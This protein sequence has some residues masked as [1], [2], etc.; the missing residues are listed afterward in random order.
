M[1]ERMTMQRVWKIHDPRHMNI[2]GEIHTVMY[3]EKKIKSLL[4][5]QRLVLFR[6]EFF[7]PCSLFFTD[8]AEVHF[9]QMHVVGP[10][11]GL[12]QRTQYFWPSETLLEAE[13]SSVWG[14]AAGALAQQWERWRS[15]EIREYSH[16]FST[17]WK[18][19]KIRDCCSACPQVTQEYPAFRTSFLG[20]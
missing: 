18:K 2:E 10:E 9:P 15:L 4:Y 16:S 19:Q 12:W 3:W 14:W 8:A 11:W 1:V 13:S 7:I 20:Y 6:P 17:E 5:L